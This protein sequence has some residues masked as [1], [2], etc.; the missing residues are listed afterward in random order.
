[1]FG[2]FNAPPG[3]LLV[4]V[5]KTGSSLTHVTFVPFVIVRTA[6]LNAMFF[7]DTVT[8]CADGAWLGWFI[9]MTPARMTAPMRSP[10]TKIVAARRDPVFCSAAT[11]SKVW[12]RSIAYHRAPFIARRV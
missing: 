11:S 8:S 2:E 3:A 12:T 6:G 9:Q 1:M 7:I 10:A 4:T 5:W